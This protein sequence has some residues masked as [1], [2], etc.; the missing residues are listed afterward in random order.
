MKLINN[1]EINK[2]SLCSPSKVIAFGEIEVE[3]NDK[4]QVSTFDIDYL[5]DALNCI[6]TMGIEYVDVRVQ[7]DFPM[8]LTGDSDTK[9][10][11]RKGLLLAP[12]IED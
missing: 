9:H 12:R 10:E 7:N 3:E 5:I 4:S 2:T 1:T 11:K 8:F 6:K